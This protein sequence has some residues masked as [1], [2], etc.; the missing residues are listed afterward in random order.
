MDNKTGEMLD[1]LGKG[2]VDSPFLS[3]M[4]VNRKYQIVWH[5]QRF[6]DEFNGGEEITT[7]TCFQAIGSEKVHED[8]PLQKSLRNQSQVR[9]YLDF[10]ENNFLFLTIPVDEEHAAKVH[11]F[12]P[13]EPDGMVEKD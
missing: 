5:N 2:L 6:A 11:I 12:L 1:K 3:V 9:G 8:C 4:I 13:K 10:G 7:G